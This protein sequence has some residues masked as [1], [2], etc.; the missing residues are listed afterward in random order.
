MSHEVG[1]IVESKSLV[2]ECWSREQNGKAWYK[3]T[4]LLKK[5]YA[6]PRAS[7]LNISDTIGNV[8]MDE[9]ENLFK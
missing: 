5:K 9:L 2:S 4:N 6:A 7:V 1:C 3:K 8:K